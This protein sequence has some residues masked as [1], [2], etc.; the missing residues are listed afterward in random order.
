M[1]IGSTLI[2]LIATL[3][4]VH[5]FITIPH[6]FTQPS[7]GL[8]QLHMADKPAGSFFNK[9]LEENDP[10]NKP[11]KPIDID[12]QV[13][14]L[15][16]A[17]TKKGP[18][19]STVGGVPLNT[20]AT[21]TAKPAKPYIGIGPPDVRANDPTNPEYDDQGYTLYKDENTG[22]KSRVF[23]A[24]VEYPCEFTMKIV[25]PKEG[26]FVA[27]IVQCVADSCEVMMEQVPYTTRVV[28]KW[29]S[30]TVKAPVQ[31][32]DMLYQ[33]YENVDRDPRVKFKF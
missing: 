1:N 25:G 15:L 16:A 11:L 3:E 32:A 5:S 33:L 6:G 20:F 7:I 9:I 10:D 28:G 13:A 30:V 22:Q 27:E 24:L 19:P 18:P 14:E 4:G 2:I 29:A 23:E 31:S 21:T 12:K 26:S 8:Q 17:K